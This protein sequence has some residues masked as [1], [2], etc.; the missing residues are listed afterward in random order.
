M[1][2]QASIIEF[3]KYRDKIIRSRTVVSN[4]IKNPVLYGKTKRPCRPPKLT[5]TARRRR[6]LRETSKGKSCS[7]ELQQKLQLDVTPRRV[8]QVLNQSSNLVYRTRKK[9]PALTKQHKE[10][11][12]EWVKEKVSWTLGKWITI[13]FSD[14]EK[15]NLDGP[16]GIQCYWHDLRKEEQVFS[17]RPLGGKSVMIWGAFSMNGK[18]E[19]VVMEGR[20]NAQKYVEVLEMSLLPFAEVDHGQDFIFQRDTAFVPFVQ[21]SLL[22]LGLETKMLPYYIGKLNHPISIQ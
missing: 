2:K 16:D 12:M 3:Y 15:F 22:M 4:F 21:Q 9:A 10:K 7:K 6:L 20:Q 17:R 14:Q 1:C 5:A 8:R 19:S 13:I 18:A 11:R